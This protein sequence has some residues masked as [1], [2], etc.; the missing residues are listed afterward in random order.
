M[1]V[2]QIARRDRFLLSHLPGSAVPGGATRHSGREKDG[3][4]ADLLLAPSV[5]IGARDKGLAAATPFLAA[6][7]SRPN[8]LS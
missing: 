7:T 8:V 5:S 4:A 6:M 1:S 2:F 3:R